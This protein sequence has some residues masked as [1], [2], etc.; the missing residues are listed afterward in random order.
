MQTAVTA[1]PPRSGAAGSASAK[2]SSRSRKHDGVK[3]KELQ[4]TTHIGT[5]SAVG[6]SMMNVFEEGE[7]R[8]TSAFQLA[9]AAKGIRH[10]EE[11][12]EWEVIRL[13][14]SR[15]RDAL[16]GAVERAA[17]DYRRRC[18]DLRE[19][20]GTQ[21]ASQA[22]ETKA[23]TVSSPPPLPISPPSNH[24]RS[25]IPLIRCREGLDVSSTPP[26]NK[27]SPLVH[28]RDN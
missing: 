11:N 23:T 18:R 8:S 6:I 17:S 19:W 21:V 24:R 7:E 10:R 26:L 27:N 13:H 4:N 25:A 20:E 15:Q 14:A 5:V 1:S 22:K 2:G 28:A 9:S 16:L 3:V 12:M